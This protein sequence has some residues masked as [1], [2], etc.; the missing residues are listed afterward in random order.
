MKQAA[1]I[2]FVRS[3]RTFV[4]ALAGVSASIPVIASFTDARDAGLV[5]VVGTIGAALAAVTAFLQNFAE[6]MPV[7]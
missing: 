4:Q 7:E 1:K 5:A 6:Q 3:V 2:A